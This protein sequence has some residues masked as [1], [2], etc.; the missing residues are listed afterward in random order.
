MCVCVCVCA[1][2]SEGGYRKQ[3]SHMQLFKATDPPT[4]SPAFVFASPDLASLS[5]GLRSNGYD[6]VGATS[7]LCNRKR[8]SI[9]VSLYHT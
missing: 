6:C 8:G 9:I 3:L 7:N 5:V 2:V 1:C 4:A